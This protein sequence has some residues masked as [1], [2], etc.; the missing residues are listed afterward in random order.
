MQEVGGESKA[1][2]HAKAKKKLVQ[3]MYVVKS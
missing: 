3:N 1:S 2:I